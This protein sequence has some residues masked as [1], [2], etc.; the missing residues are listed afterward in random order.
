MSTGKTKVGAADVSFVDC[1]AGKCLGFAFKLSNGFQPMPYKDVEAQR[2]LS[3]CFL[4]SAWMSD[5]LQERR[6]SGSPA[7]PLCGAPRAQSPSDFCT[8]PMLSLAAAPDSYISEG[9]PEENYGDS[10]LLRVDGDPGVGQSAS[11]MNARLES[12][13]DVDSGDRF[14]SLVSFDP[15]AIDSFIAGG[16]FTSATLVLTA[17]ESEHTPGDED[18]ID[19]HPLMGGFAEGEGEVDLEQVAPGPIR[20]SALGRPRLARRIGGRQ[21]A[22]G[23][24]WDCAIDDNPANEL[25]EDCHDP[26]EH[27]GGDE[28]HATALPARSVRLERSTPGT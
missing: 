7:D 24:T 25:T 2:K 8:D 12:A 6:E 26:W 23:V 15:E 1:P 20:P 18:L 10:S 19:V 16:A 5:G 14:R 11:S 3:H 27:E 9:N 4:E 13:A 21:N 22:P 28:G 17:A